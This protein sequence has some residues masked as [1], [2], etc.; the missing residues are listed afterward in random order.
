MAVPFSALSKAREE[1][2]VLLFVFWF[3]FFRFFPALTPLGDS[4]APPACVCVCDAQRESASCLCSPLLRLLTRCVQLDVT[5]LCNVEFAVTFHGN[6]VTISTRGYGEIRFG[7][8][9]ET[10]TI[11][12]YIPDLK[13]ESCLFGTRRQAWRGTWEIHCEQVRLFSLHG[14]RDFG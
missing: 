8:L 10:Y 14:P 3:V 7:K 6:S 13:I 2:R 11:S 12:K 9:G 5:F 1:G 4:G